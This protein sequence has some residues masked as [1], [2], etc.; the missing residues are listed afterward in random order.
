[1]IGFRSSLAMASIF[2]CTLHAPLRAQSLS[3]IEVISNPIGVS[4][5]QSEWKL[6]EYYRTAASPSWASSDVKAAWTQGYL[7]RGTTV[8]VVDD[9]A[10]TPV[11]G[12][13]VDSQPTQILPHGSWTSMQV[14]MLAPLAKVEQVQFGNAAI[15]LSTGLNIMSLSYGIYASTIYSGINYNAQ[16]Q[17]LIDMASNGTAVVVKAAGNDA[18]AIG[19]ANSSGKKDFFNDALKNGL[20]TIFVGALDDNGTADKKTSKAWYSNYAG[21][22]AVAQKRMLFVGVRADITGLYGTSFAAPIVSAYASLLGSK[23][24]SASATAISNQLLNTARTDTIAFYDPTVY[25][26]GEASLSRALAPVTI[27]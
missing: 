6:I 10:A 17:S 1:M 25:G 9:Y 8:T 24:R 18:V 2:V 21:S 11:S 27:R 12:K 20:S 7:G 16:S 15:P 13:L 23:F 22:D 19:A 3:A 14:G 26:K 4:I 5:T